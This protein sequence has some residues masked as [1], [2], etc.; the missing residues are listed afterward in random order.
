MIVPLVVLAVGAHAD[1]LHRAV[2]AASFDHPE[3]EPAR[4]TSSSRCSGPSWRSR[5][6]SRSIFMVRRRRCWR[7]VGIALAMVFYRRR[8][9]GAGARV[10]AP[11]SRGFVRL[12]AGQVPHRRAVRPR[13][14][15]ARSARSRAACSRSSTASSSTRSWSRARACSSTCSRGSRAP[16]RAATASA[17]W[18]CSRSASRCWSTSPRQPTLPF[19][20]L[21]V[22]QTGRAVEIDARRG[23]R[24]ADPR[25]SSTR[26]TSATA[27][28]SSRARPREQRHDYDRPGTLHDPRDDQRPAL[29]DGRRLQ[30]KG[31]G[32]VMGVLAWITLLPLFG[33]G[34]VMLVPREEE[35]IHRGLGLLHGAGHVRGVAADPARLRRRARP[36][37]SWRSTRSGSR[38][39]ASASTW[40]ST[41]SRCG[42][43]C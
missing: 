42:W 34:L 28:R 21:K 14:S 39:S 9:Q 10:R 12:V 35:A 24:A 1:R 41:A 19:T 25:R 13:A 30:G 27:A 23:N 29:G 4:R 32:A 33:A 22:T 2:P 36:A 18:R 6:T 3:C 20:K 8:L 15:S 31:R 38:R 7:C 43:C 17:T 11:S 26:S 16:S 37:F 40:A 5:T